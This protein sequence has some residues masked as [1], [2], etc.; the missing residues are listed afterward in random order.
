MSVKLLPTAKYSMTGAFCS[1]SDG[2]SCVN[3][4]LKFCVNSFDVL[5]WYDNKYTHAENNAAS[6]NE[7]KPKPKYTE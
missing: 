6:L 1:G 5:K 3:M 2:R 4:D 7:R